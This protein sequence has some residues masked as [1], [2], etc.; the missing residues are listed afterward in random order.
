MSI[1]SV[2]VD[3]KISDLNYTHGKLKRNN[4]FKN[5]VYLLDESKVLIIINLNNKTESS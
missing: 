3:S 2:K 5:T 1:I 4:V